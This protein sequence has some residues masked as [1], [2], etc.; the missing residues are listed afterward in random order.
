MIRRA[1]ALCALIL[2]AAAPL[3]QMGD[4]A[5]ERDAAAMTAEREA[6]EVTAIQVARWIR[7]HKSGL[8]V[9]DLRPA[10]DFKSYHIPGSVN[11]SL[12]TVVSRDA[13]V[14]DTVVLLADNGS[15]ADEAR[16]RIHHDSNGKV[17][18]LRGGIDEW[19][20][21]VMN[22]VLSTTATPEQE[23]AFEEQAALSRYFGGQPRRGDVE[24]RKSAADR[25]TSMRRRGC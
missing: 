9:I 6:D 11:R 17:F 4:A 21:E 2:G 3:V 25:I 22:P 12:Q 23:R 13:S 19:L 14:D 18:I 1:L 15:H 20:A 24:K 5:P 16:A 7:E 10:A 8:R